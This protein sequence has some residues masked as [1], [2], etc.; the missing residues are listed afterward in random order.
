MHEDTKRAKS[1]L[2]NISTVKDFETL[3]ETVLLSEEEQ[4]IVTL[5]YKEQ[6]SLSYIADELGLSEVSVKKKH[7][8]ILRKINKAIGSV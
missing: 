4:K 6:K 8:K 5:H 3:L 1:T 7:S 2:K